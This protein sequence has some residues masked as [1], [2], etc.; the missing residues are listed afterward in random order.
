MNDIITYSL[1]GVFIILS[2]INLVCS[3]FC[4][5]KLMAFEKSTH[6][7]QYVP[8]DPEFEKESEKQLEE[9][10]KR[11]KE[12]VEEDFSDILQEQSI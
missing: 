6:Q 1:L 4:M 10:N 12:Y 9:V 3:L 7:V 2:V 8:I 11:F 5:I